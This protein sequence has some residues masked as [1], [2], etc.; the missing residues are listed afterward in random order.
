MENQKR[1]AEFDSENV[2][3][4]VKLNEDLPQVSMGEIMPQLDLVMN[5]LDNMGNEREA[6]VS[7][8]I[9]ILVIM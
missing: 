3:K 7:F 9:I 2:S 6:M 4:S 5:E 1:K 8:L